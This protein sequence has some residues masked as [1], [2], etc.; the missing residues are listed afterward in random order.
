MRH[1]CPYSQN[2]FVM[3]PYFAEVMKLKVDTRTLHQEVQTDK[4]QCMINP[5]TYN[6]KTTPRALL[7]VPGLHVA[8]VP[9]AL[10]THYIY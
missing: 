6:N 2:R 8:E 1:F 3:L 10:L 4:C 7:D 5:P 9:L